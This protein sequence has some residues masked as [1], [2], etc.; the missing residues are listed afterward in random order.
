[1]AFTVQTDLPDLAMYRVMPSRNGS[2]LEDLM[3][4]VMYRCPSKMSEQNRV[5][6]GM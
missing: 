2:V 6:S 4:I 1:M 3:L 5:D